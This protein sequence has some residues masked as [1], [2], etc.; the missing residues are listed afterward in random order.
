MSG[1]ELHLRR[2]E[3]CD[4]ADPVAAVV[5]VAASFRLRSFLFLLPSVK[6]WW[7]IKGEAQLNRDVLE[8]NNDWC[9]IQGSGEHGPESV[10]STRVSP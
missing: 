9:W 8:E 1:P 3:M 5:A 4:P 10:S 2:P 7:M 6:L